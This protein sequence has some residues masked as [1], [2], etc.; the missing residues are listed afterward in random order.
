MVAHALL[1]R[2]RGL[3]LRCLGGRAF[4]GS[5]AVGARSRLQCAAMLVLV[6]VSGLG[7]AVIPL[8]VIAA[9]RGGAPWRLTWSLRGVVSLFVSLYVSW[10]V[11]GLRARA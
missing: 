2:A 3:E 8:G 9:L 1:L 11:A 6:V 4:G 10:A 7:A 5:S